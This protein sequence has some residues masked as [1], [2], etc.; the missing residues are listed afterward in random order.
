MTVPYRDPLF[1]IPSPEFLFRHTVTVS[2]DSQVAVDT[3]D[4]GWPITG[5]A[6]QVTT[7]AYVAPPDP[8][9]LTP[10]GQAV[11]VVVLVP[12]GTAVEHRDTIIVDPG[13]QLAA[14][15]AG[16]YRITAVRPNPSHCRILCTRVTDPEGAEA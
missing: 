10:A 4:A 11:D 2:R 15:H 6:E 9:T 7:R 3:D 13:Q 5:S 1:P 12:N 14:Q 16:R 8:R